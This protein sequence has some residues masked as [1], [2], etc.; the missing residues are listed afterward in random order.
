MEDL[1]IEIEI[2]NE[3]E[4]ELN[5]YY[6]LRD[7]SF[8]SPTYMLTI[9]ILIVSGLLTILFMAVRSGMKLN[10]GMLI[11][12]ALLAVMLFYATLPFVSTKIAIFVN[13]IRLK[14]FV[15]NKI[16]ILN[17]CVY[18]L[19][20]DGILGSSRAGNVNLIWTAIKKINVN[21]EYIFIPTK[22]HGIHMIPKRY[23]NSQEK[24]NKF[25]ETIKENLSKLKKET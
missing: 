5:K 16:A 18:K 3:D 11:I 10:D 23:F 6:F 2:T 7:F 1:Q 9:T 19:S 22:K 21:E 15:R 13:I 25:I 14:F 8:G 17:K 12:L 20:P 4:L 24:C